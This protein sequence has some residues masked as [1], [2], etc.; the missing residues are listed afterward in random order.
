MTS[1]VA[2]CR[3]LYLA[4]RVSSRRR[5]VYPSPVHAVPASRRRGRPS[6]SCWRSPPSRSSAFSRGSCGSGAAGARSRLLG[7]GGAVRLGLAFI[8]LPLVSPLD[9]LGDRYLLSAHMLQHVLIGDVAPALILVALRGPLLFFAVPTAAPQRRRPHAPAAAVR[10]VAPPARRR[11]SSLWALAFGA[12]AHPGRLRLRRPPPG[13]PRPRARE[14]RHRR[15]PRLDAP[16]R[17]RRAP[18][19]SRAGAASR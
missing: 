2:L 5:R 6:R 16:D 3:D 8:V 18:T 11:R 15:V 13:R 7:A 4:R 17:P 10:V 14:L 12:L 9:V 19:A 1:I